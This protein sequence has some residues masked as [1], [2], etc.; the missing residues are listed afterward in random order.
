MT[1]VCV[2]F[3][4]LYKV[5]RFCSYSLL[6]SHL[7]YRISLLSLRYNFD[8]KHKSCYNVNETLFVYKLHFCRINGEFNVHVSDLITIECHRDERMRCLSNEWQL[9]VASCQRNYQ[10]EKSWR[11]LRRIS[12][13]W[14]IPLDM[15]VLE[16]FISVNI[17]HITI[18]FYNF[19]AIRIICSIYVWI[20]TLFLLRSL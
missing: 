19:E 8:S 14:A 18:Y 10:R 13:G 3:V 17:F 7:C 5:V 4:C 12:G 6:L 15:V 1:C 11:T 9:Q 16:T 2:C 20:I